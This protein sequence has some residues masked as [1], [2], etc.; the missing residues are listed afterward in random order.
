MH[1]FIL[2]ILSKNME[3]FRIYLKSNRFINL[4]YQKDQRLQTLFNKKKSENGI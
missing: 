3:I 2:S 1:F 4:G